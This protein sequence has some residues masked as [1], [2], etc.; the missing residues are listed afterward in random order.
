MFWIEEVNSG[1]FKLFQ[2]QKY[3]GEKCNENDDPGV[4]YHDTDEWPAHPPV[5][6]WFSGGILNRFMKEWLLRM[7]EKR[8]A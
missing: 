1:I 3:P 6:M 8:P 2:L 4:Y 5:G 7:E